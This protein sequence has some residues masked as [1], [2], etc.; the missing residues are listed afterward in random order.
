M[1][2]NVLLVMGLIACTATASAQGPAQQPAKDTA[3]RPFLIGDVSAASVTVDG[4]SPTTI[5]GY[6][7][8]IGGPSLRGFQLVG[9]L[10]RGFGVNRSHPEGYATAGVRHSWPSLWRFR[11]YVDAGAGAARM[12][13]DGQRP[14]VPLLSA[15][16][17]AHVQLTRHLTLDAGYRVYRYFGDAD[18]SRG[19]PT[20]GF[21][22]TF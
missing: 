6:D 9:N 21:G 8:T 2:R 22:V 15:G 19:R 10:G 7:A 18:S 11:P 1:M 16:L 12:K 17:G 13:L 20:L 4:G 14:M 3:P 5:L